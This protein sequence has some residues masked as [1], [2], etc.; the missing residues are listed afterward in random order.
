MS[1][2]SEAVVRQRQNRKPAPQRTWY[3]MSSHGI[4]FFYVATHPD[5]TIKEL[6]EALHLTRRTIWELVGDLRRAGMVQ[7]RKSG[8]RHHYF[9][10][11][12]SLGHHPAFEG[13]TVREVIDDMMQQGWNLFGKPA[14]SPRL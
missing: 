4:A 6:T 5:C 14:E 8:R 3:L 13:K 7:V 11:L 9:A 10:D 1:K 2:Q 12:N